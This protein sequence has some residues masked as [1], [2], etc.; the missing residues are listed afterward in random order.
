MSK[1]KAKISKISVYM[2][3]SKCLLL[4]NEKNHQGN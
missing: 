4:T 2:I 1:V 3:G